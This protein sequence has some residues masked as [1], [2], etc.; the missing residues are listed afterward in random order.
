MFESKM[1]KMEFCFEPFLFESTLP[2]WSLGPQ[3]RMTMKTLEHNA[4]SEDWTF[5]N[6]LWLK[7]GWKIVFSTKTDDYESMLGWITILQNSQDFW[8]KITHNLQKD[9]EL[10][11]V[12]AYKKLFVRSNEWQMHFNERWLESDKRDVNS[13]EL[14]R[15]RWSADFG[16]MMKWMS[17]KA[18]LQI[19][20]SHWSGQMIKAVPLIST[21]GLL[22]SLSTTHQGASKDDSLGDPFG[23]LVYSHMASI[24]FSLF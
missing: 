14:E 10:R 19:L 4:K 17:G 24:S 13:R 20:L 6:N 12:H 9:Q 1:P 23:H 18:P 22:G 5:R 16:Y 11:R 21:P 2:R 7:Y 8:A 3:M 15:L